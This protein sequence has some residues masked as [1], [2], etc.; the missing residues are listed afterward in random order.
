MNKNIFKK[1]FE[2]VKPSEEL[3]KSVLDVHNVPAV[4]KKTRR[5]S[6]KRILGTAAAV[7]GLLICGITAAAVTGVINFKELFG[8]H[9]DL[10]ND[11]LGSKLMAQATDVVYTVSDDD[12][13]VGLKGITG[14]IGS[15]Y[16]IIEIT[17]VDGTPV[18]EHFLNTLNDMANAKWL[19]DYCDASQWSGDYGGFINN[20]G[21]LEFF[22]DIQNRFGI[23]DGTT[24]SAGEENLVLENEF[25]RYC[26]DIDAVYGEYPDFYGTPTLGWWRDPIRGMSREEVIKYEE[27]ALEKYGFSVGMEPLSDEELDK[28]DVSSFMLL[29]LKWE[30][31][32]TYHAPE[33]SSIKLVCER[34][35][36]KTVF[37]DEYGETEI[38]IINIEIG[39][40]GGMINYEYC[41]D[42]DREKMFIEPFSEN[43]EICLIMSD[44]SRVSMLVSSASGSYNG[45]DSAACTFR[46]DFAG[47]SSDTV[48][49][50]DVS[51]GRAIS[52]NGTVYDLQ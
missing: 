24:I 19:Y 38:T 50:I 13:R 21:N 27:R 7:C 1:A 8:K 11:E 51:K 47:E 25:E 31:S 40:A 32:F 9:I 33:I 36:K 5:V 18:T 29:P 26:E 15:L 43:N 37:H 41:I 39:A 14:D 17:R 12:Y 46:L 6:C 23:L 10:D 34:P 48:R 49:Y 44:G 20:K 28:I 45:G 42:K 52:I 4:P 22:L 3:L 16:A 30:I 35:E 2:N